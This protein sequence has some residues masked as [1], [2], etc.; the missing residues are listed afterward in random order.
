M[1]SGRLLFR[2]AIFLN[3]SKHS[4]KCSLLPHAEVVFVSYKSGLK[5][6]T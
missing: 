6:D 4:T 3:L 5:D 2:K 1:G